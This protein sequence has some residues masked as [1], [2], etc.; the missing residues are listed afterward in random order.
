[1][2]YYVIKRI[3]LG[4]SQ[5]AATHYIDMSVEIREIHYMS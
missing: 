1:M 4:L 5:L 3:V 2:I